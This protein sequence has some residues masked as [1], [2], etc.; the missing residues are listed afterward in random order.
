MRRIFRCGPEKIYKPQ[1]FIIAL[2]VI[3]KNK[4]H[5]VVSYRI[6]HQ[7]YIFFQISSKNSPKTHYQH[8]TRIKE[9][10]ITK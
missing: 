4:T 1:A 2:Y 8:L 7:K 3:R 5:H 9:I 6:Y 10:V